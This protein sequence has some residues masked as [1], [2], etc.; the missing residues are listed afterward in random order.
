MPPL[1]LSMN[2]VAAE[3]FC[4]HWKFRL[5]IFGEE[6]AFLPLTLN[7]ALKDDSEALF[8]V[9]LVNLLPNAE[10]RFDR[11]CIINRGMRRCP[12]EEYR[13][14]LVRNSDF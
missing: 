2:Q 11:P 10:D 14:S 8:T 6:K 3:K 9:N 12:T 1:L 7:D 5:E 13:K 4:K